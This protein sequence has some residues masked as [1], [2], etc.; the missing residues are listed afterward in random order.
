MHGPSLTLLILYPA[1]FTSITPQGPPFSRIKVE[2]VP[3]KDYFGKDVPL[4]LGS[5][6]MLS[7]RLLEVEPVAW[8]PS[9]ALLLSSSPS[10]GTSLAR[11]V[12]S[13]PASDAQSPGDWRSSRRLAVRSGGG[14]RLGTPLAGCSALSSSSGTRPLLGTCLAALGP[15][16]SR[17]CLSPGRSPAGPFP[18]PCPDRQVSSVPFFLG[19]LSAISPCSSNGSINL[20]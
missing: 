9:H 13:T 19:L 6:G 7:L 4:G 8:A 20:R 14:R 17:R 15:I 16:C 11:L 2:R 18:Q 3:S 10:W 12:P 1:T 5:W